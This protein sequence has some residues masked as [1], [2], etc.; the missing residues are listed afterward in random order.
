MSRLVDDEALSNQVVDGKVRLQVKDLG[1]CLSGS[2]EDV[3][4]DVSFS[5]SAG[6]VLGLV[7]E[8]GSGKTTLALALL[9]YTKRGIDIVRG[10]I[11]LDG[12][13]LLGMSPAELRSNRGR[14]VA[15]VPQDPAMAL[16]PALRIGTQLREA[17]QV[18]KDFTGDVGERLA[19]IIAD[20][21][22]ANEGDLLQ[23]YPHQLSGGQQQRVGLA[24]AF[25]CR[26]G[27]IVLDEP[28]TG[29][30]VT[31]Q[32]HVLTTVRELCSSYGVAAVYVSHDLAVVRGL[33]STV[34]V[35]YAGR[36]IE[37]GPTQAVFNQ[38]T[39]P[40]TRGLLAA[41]PSL[42]RAEVL[43]GITGQPPRPG[44]RPKGCSF[45]ARCPLAL[46]VCG[47]EEPVPTLVGGRLVRCFRA[48]EERVDLNEKKVV[49]PAQEPHESAPM[50]AVRTLNASYGSSQVLFDVN[51][52][53]GR[54][55]CLAVVGESGS[56]KTTLARCLVGLNSNWS[57]EIKFNGE[58][59][60]AGCRNRPKNLLRKVQY[61]FQ[62]PY[63][64]LNPRKTIGQIIGQPL[65]QIPDL[66]YSE[67]SQRVVQ[68][69]EDVS[70][71]ADFMSRLPDQL[72]GGERQRVA[73]ARA[74]VVDPELLVCDE[75]TSSLDVSAQ[76]IIVELLRK[77][78]VERGLGMVFITHNLAL[79]RSIA[80]SVVVLNQGHIVEAGDVDKV[81]SHP[82][83]PYTSRLMADAPRL[84][85]PI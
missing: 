12:A 3:V 67:R 36:V 81:L 70:L 83:D 66:L 58:E 6:E 80:Q 59:L 50:L 74:L 1:L 10:E 15:Y 48:G 18:H 31:T 16:N 71:G 53:V 79:V 72:S 57:G 49:A 54:A 65:E 28:T 29:L 23:R 20:T 62:N 77:L 26:P 33:V 43:R 64:A 52:N 46:P 82:T 19:E 76:A 63:S 42:D 38:P 21:R 73:I 9:G 69:L 25:A 4:S 13:N 2:G 56:G 8:S 5:V 41:V 32:R 68:V 60:V 44:R 11:L 27:L 45:A 34:A 7:G 84:N 17:M 75:V 47:E 51:L 37:L 61:I 22:L 40:Y 78:Q 85:Q 14:R 55:A 24:M 35:M 39:H 30:D